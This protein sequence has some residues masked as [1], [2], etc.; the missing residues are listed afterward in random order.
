MN[1]GYWKVTNNQAVETKV[2]IATASN[3]SIGLILKP[4]QFCVCMDQMTRM[5]DAQVKRGFVSI[6]EGFANEHD[7]ET[8]V[9]FDEGYVPEAHVEERVR[10]YKRGE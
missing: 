8:G 9:A 10:E 2:A 3:G 6:D 7:L 1:K 5:L 4:N